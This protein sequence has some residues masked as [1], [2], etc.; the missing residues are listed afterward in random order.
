[1]TSWIGLHGT[2]RVTV[3]RK[4]SDWPQ[5]VVI[6]GA[7]Q[8]TIPGMVGASGTVNGGDWHLTVEH[9]PGG[10]GRQGEF[11]QAGPVGERD[12]R[13]IRTLVSKDRYW[14]GDSDPD[15]LVLRL[16]HVGARFEVA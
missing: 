4:D 8:G 1:M 13:V 6:S 14:P 15:D 11:V 7:A 16:E 5:R 9:D 10:G 3:V 2:W 12:G